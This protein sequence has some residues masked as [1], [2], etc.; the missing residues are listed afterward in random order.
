VSLIIFI[1]AKFAW[2]YLRKKNKRKKKSKKRSLRGDAERNHQ[3][4][5]EE[6]ERLLTSPSEPEED[7]A[8]DSAA[9]MIP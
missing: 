5:G 8:P 2:K 7:E 3:H 1:P 9:G 4:S 6:L